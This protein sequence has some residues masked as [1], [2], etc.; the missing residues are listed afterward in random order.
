MKIWNKDQFGDTFKRYK[1]IEGELNRMEVNTIHRQLF[2]Q[3]VII[4][5]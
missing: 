1:K 4:R 2:T 5:K 3:E